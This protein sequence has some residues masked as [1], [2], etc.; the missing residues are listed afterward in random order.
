MLRWELAST[1]MML[2]CASQISLTTQA[3]RRF[4]TDPVPTLPIAPKSPNAEPMPLRAPPCCPAAL[5][6]P[7][8]SASL[9]MTRKAARELLTA[10]GLRFEV[11]KEP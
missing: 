2:C 7:S 10:E 8:C 9:E 6:Q 11:H 1:Y 4:Y 5:L 3:P